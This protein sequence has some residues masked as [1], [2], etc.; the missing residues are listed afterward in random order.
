MEEKNSSFLGDDEFDKWWEYAQIIG[1]TIKKPS[2][3]EN[4]RNPTRAR[5][6][7]AIIVPPLHFECSRWQINSQDSVLTWSKTLSSWCLVNRAFWNLDTS[8]TGEK[9]DP[10]KS[11]TWDDFIRIA[12]S[13]QRQL[14]CAQVNE[15]SELGPKFLALWDEAEK[16]GW[17]RCMETLDTGILQYSINPPKHFEC[18]RKAWAQMSPFAFFVPEWDANVDI[19][20]WFWDKNVRTCG[21]HGNK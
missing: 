20:N 18:S 15:W 21:T 17:T 4:K 8:A 3:P 2:S 16:C 13:C 1:W 6:P 10:K 12:K 7:H 19:P 14:K 9:P 11:R 5:E